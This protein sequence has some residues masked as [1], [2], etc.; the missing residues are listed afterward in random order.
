MNP[1]FYPFVLDGLFSCG[2]KDAW[3]TPIIMKNGRPGVI[4]SALLEETCRQPALDF[5]FAQTTTI[6]IRWSDVRRAELARKTVIVD[7]P[8]GDI[9]VKVAYSADGSVLNAAPEYKACAAAA[10]AQDIPLKEVYTATL[11]EFCSGTAL[12]DKPE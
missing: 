4:L 9:P 6:G 7:S 12:I 5:I 2:A 3:L 8:F 11:L 10:K 1:E